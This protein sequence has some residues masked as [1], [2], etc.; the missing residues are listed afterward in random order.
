MARR[1][2]RPSTAEGKPASRLRPVPTT[3]AFLTLMSEIDRLRGAALALA[4]KVGRSSDPAAQYLLA[5]QAL[6]FWQRARTLAERLQKAGGR[7]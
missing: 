5:E 2:I 6:E 3:P 1:I 4:E 7:A